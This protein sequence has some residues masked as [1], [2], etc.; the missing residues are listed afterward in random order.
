VVSAKKEAL[1]YR[2]KKKI[3]R[4]RIGKKHPRADRCCLHGRRQT[5]RAV[6][7]KKER[8]STG[9][10]KGKSSISGKPEDP[11]RKLLFSAEQ[12]D[13]GGK[14]KILAWVCV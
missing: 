10:E 11:L 5:E 3:A 14:G 4:S 7:P 1:A 9:K 13:K 2:I 6:L 8:E 12:K